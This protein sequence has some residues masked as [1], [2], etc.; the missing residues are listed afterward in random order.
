MSGP[1]EIPVG[2]AGVRLL[3][4]ER[5][6]DH[7]GW[8]AEDYRRSW[9]PGAREMVQGN[10]SFSRAGVLR[11][12]HFHRAQ[13]DWW[14]VLSGCAFV[15]LYD[16]RAGSPT[17]GTGLG[18]RL[19]A[20]EELRGLYIPAGVAHGFYAERDLL[21]HYLVDAEHT[22]ADEHG[23]AWDDPALGIAWPDASPVTS[24][25]D[26]SNPPLAEVLRDPPPYAP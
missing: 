6:P 10:V 24:E 5:H 18:L 4:L 16:L 13:A 25:R 7:R 11:G 9:L 8:F 26:R 1:A 20:D 19:D 23:V 12:L 2:I 22:G 15:G 17:Q 3:A 14:T 21:L